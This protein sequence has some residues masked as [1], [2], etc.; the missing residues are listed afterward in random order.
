MGHDELFYE[1]NEIIRNVPSYDELSEGIGHSPMW[2]GRIQNALYNWNYVVT[3]SAIQE[4]NH[5]TNQNVA[6]G[7]QAYSEV[8]T[9]LH[10][11]H[12][13]LR[14]KSTRPKS[15]AIGQGA[16]FDYYDEVRRII[17]TASTDIYFIDPYMYSDFVSK[18]LIHV[19]NTVSIRLLSNE[20][21]GL[22][23][24]SA[25]ELSRQHN[26]PIEI[27]KADDIHDRLVFI[28]NNACFQSGA[29][30]KDG[31]LNASTTL[32][33]ITDAFEAVHATYKAL[34]DTSET[35]FKTS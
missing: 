26:L 7:R 2:L 5:I 15:I 14:L 24:T 11:A 13:D 4:V 18:Y 22:L 10:R 28:D 12:N 25:N 33:Q 21:L 6:R 16:F 30:F 23:T 31:A 29:S 17:E 35:V 20:K 27:K 34:W 3:V 19:K 1:I 32:T 9:A 8:M